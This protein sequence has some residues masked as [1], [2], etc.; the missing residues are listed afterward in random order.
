MKAKAWLEKIN[1]QGKIKNDD[2]TKTL[3]TIPDTLELPDVWVN[4]FDQ[5]FLTRE[6]ALADNKVYDTIRGE[7]LD[8]VKLN[9]KEY[10]PYLDAKDQ[11]EISKE[12]KAFNQ[13]K[14]L[15]EAFGRSIEKIKTENP[16]ND[17]K[18]KELTKINKQYVEKIT[19]QENDF[20]NKEKE[21]QQKFEAEKHGMKLDWTLDK[22]L[23]EFTF[24]DEYK[25]VR[26][27]LTKGVIDKIK[28]EN[29]LV[30]DDSGQIQIHEKG[31]SGV[32]KQKFNGNEAVTLDK[33]LEEPLK[34]FLKKNTG[35]GAQPGANG[36]S[37]GG[38]N[39]SQG[40]H[41]PSID[42][43]NKMTLDQRRRAGVGYVR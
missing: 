5:E 29:V 8:G 32:T 24:A 4:M 41:N 15:K 2:F 26:P 18:V 38:Q 36:G 3:E 33:L 21:I 1:N 10:L 20:K 28:A 17:E 37:A 12:P 7:V 9:I 23:S 25:E 35:G 42:D 40:R 39:G 16:S 13:L 11:D 27:H 30:L 31:E 34:P 22:K 19:A 43:P 14:M 6:R